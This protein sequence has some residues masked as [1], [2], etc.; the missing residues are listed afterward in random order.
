MVTEEFGYAE[1]QGR[2]PGWASTPAVELRLAH[3]GWPIEFGITQSGFSLFW[4]PGFAVDACAATE[5]PF[6][7]VI[8]GEAGFDGLRETMRRVDEAPAWRAITGVVRDGAAAPVAGAWVHE[9]DAAG[10]YLSRTRTAEDGTFTIHAPAETVR[11]VPQLRGLPASA[12]LEVADGETDVELVFAPDSRLHVVATE[13]GSGKPLPV[14]VQVV[15]AVPQPATPAAY[16]VLDEQDGR[17]H[18]EFVMSGE[19]TLRIPPGDHRSSS[20]AATSTSCSTPP[21]PR[22][23]ARRSRSLR[24]WSTRWTAPAPCAPTSTSTRSTRPTP[25]TPSSTRCAAPS[26]T[27]STSPSPASTS[28]SS[29]SS[30]SSSRWG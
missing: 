12:G 1:P 14:R 28:G 22:R 30:P 27:A 25:A 15:P 26:P 18:Q 19:A 17:L 13:T 24:R 29:T 4:G 20:A 23:P 6:L 7:E 8:A 2:S 16:G 11:L 10:K 3:A 5:L 21:S 9:V